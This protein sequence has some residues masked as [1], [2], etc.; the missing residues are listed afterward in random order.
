MNISNINTIQ[1]SFHI[2]FCLN[3]DSICLESWTDVKKYKSKKKLIDVIA[4]LKEI[5][6]AAQISLPI[7]VH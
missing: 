5:S 3:K 4:V 6:P 2:Y 1:L 7:R